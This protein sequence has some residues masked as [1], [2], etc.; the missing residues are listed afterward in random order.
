[1]LNKLTILV[2][3]LAM[4]LTASVPI[5]AQVSGE[6]EFPRV[7][8]TGYGNNVL[9]TS[10]DTFIDCGSISADTP[11]SERPSDEVSS[12]ADASSDDLERARQLCME[13]GIL[14]DI[15]TSVQ[16]GDTVR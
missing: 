4:L 1:M 6:D 15:S 5:L 3:L 12:P 7:A 14:P 2:A 13:N 9:Q 11:E 10:N 8:D 16:Y